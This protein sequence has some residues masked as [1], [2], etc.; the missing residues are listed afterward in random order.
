V[1]TNVLAEPFDEYMPARSA[2]RLNRTVRGILNFARKKP[3]GAICGLIVIFFIVIGDAVPVTINAA[4]HVA[5]LGEPMPYVADIV[6]KNVGVIYPYSRQRLSERLQSPSKAHLLGTDHLGR[7]ILSR[8]FYGARVAVIISLGAVL[9]SELIG[10]TIGIA[11][12]YYGGL[13]DSIGYRAVDV[14]QALPGLVLLITV[15]GIFHSGMW[16]MVIAIAIISIPGASR[17]IRSQTISVMATPFI[18]SSRVIGAGDARIMLKHVLPNVFHLMVLSST[19]RLGST[20]LIEASLS[21]LGYGLGSTYPSWGQMLSIEGRDYM[22]TQPALAIFPGVAIAL[23][24][25]SY[26]LFGDAIRDVLD[27]RLR[28]SR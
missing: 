25:F 6:Q 14:L 28:G 1:A 4:T 23:L 8:L 9:L 5:G 26:N 24:V 12:A 7:D 3:L 27:P 17:L 10:A 21:F 19:V 18:E 11:A 22:R 16:Q 20:V 15:L 13:V 2:S